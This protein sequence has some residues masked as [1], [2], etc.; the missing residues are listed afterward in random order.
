VRGSSDTLR[1]TTAGRRAIEALPRQ[2]GTP[3][4]DW[5][6]VIETKE[7]G[8]KTKADALG[9]IVTYTGYHAGQIGMVVKYG[10]GA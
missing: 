7:F 9:R 5:D 10:G 4:A 8:K 6:T 1:P 3:D 2:A